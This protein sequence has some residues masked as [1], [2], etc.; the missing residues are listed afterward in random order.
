MLSTIIIDFGESNS[1]NSIYFGELNSPNSIFNRKNSDDKTIRVF[2][3][4]NIICKNTLLI[5]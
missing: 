3:Y 4:R 2:L 5:V 1:P